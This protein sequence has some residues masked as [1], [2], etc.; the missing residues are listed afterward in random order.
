M[1]RK[2]R[3]H[4]RK[5]NARKPARKRT[6]ISGGKEHNA[7]PGH[8]GT[9]KRKGWSFEQ[10]CRQLKPEHEAALKRF[11]RFARVRAR[12]SKLPEAEVVALEALVRAVVTFR[13]PCSL[14]EKREIALFRWIRRKVEFALRNLAAQY[15]ASA[16]RDA[17]V[18]FEQRFGHRP[19]LR[20]LCR[21]KKFNPRHVLNV[22]EQ[23]A[24]ELELTWESDTVMGSLLDEMA[25]WLPEVLKSNSEG[26]HRVQQTM[27]RL[28][29]ADA[30]VLTL[31]HLCGY[32]EEDIITFLNRAR[33]A[34]RG[35]PDQDL[36]ENLL[37]EFVAER[38]ERLKSPWDSSLLKIKARGL[39]AT[40]LHRARIR[41]TVVFL[42]LKNSGSWKDS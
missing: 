6:K 22:W 38:V 28:K 5:N 13:S 4:I 40:S 33:R 9:G 12:R 27:A 15:P 20:E 11:E 23:V 35:A 37:D 36:L 24:R 41:F 31:K 32:S 19:T 25:G 29:A 1:K 39:L 7:K 8:K 14:K 42:R 18:Q 30:C 3:R 26:I 34:T 2:R 10:I 21:F 16:V 17:F